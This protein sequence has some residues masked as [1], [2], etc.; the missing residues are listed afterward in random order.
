MTNARASC[1]WMRDGLHRQ[2]AGDGFRSEALRL[3]SGST[4]AGSLT[5]VGIFQANKKPAGLLLPVL[6]MDATPD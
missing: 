1:G 4:P 2:S 3:A 6:F 5:P